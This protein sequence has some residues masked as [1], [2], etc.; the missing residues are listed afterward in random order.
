VNASTANKLIYRNNTVRIYRNNFS[1]PLYLNDLIDRAQASESASP[2]TPKP[3][4]PP[5]QTFILRA[6]LV[7]LTGHV[8]MNSIANEPAEEILTDQPSL[9]ERR[10]LINRVAASVHF[11]RSARLRDFLLYVGRQ[12]LKNGCPEIN[13][14]EIGVKVFGRSSSY[15]RSQDNIVRVNATELR[16]R[17]DLYFATEGAH[18]PL[19]LEIPRGGYRPVFHRRLPELQE[20]L[21]PGSEPPVLENVLHHDPT[22]AV[23]KDS[24][25]LMQVVWAAVTLALA[26]LCVV[27]FLQN[28]TMRRAIYTWEG[29]P[30]VASLWTDFVR[31]HQE[32]D[33]VLPD[34]SVSVSEEILGHP[35]SL[36]DYLDHNYLRLSQSLDLSSDRRVDLNQIFAHNLVTMGD[37]HAA[38][39]I[40]ALTPLS[41]TLHLTFSRFYTADSV[42]R[43][44]FILIGGKKANPWVRL[45]DD[46]MNFSLDYDNVHSQSFVANRHPQAGEQPTYA[47]PMD[48]NAFVG[49]SVVAYLPNP[50]RT[51]N[52]IILAGTDSD[53]TSAAAEFLTSEEQLDKLRN[54]LH[55]RQF[56]YFEVLLKTSRLSGTSFSAEPLAFRTYPEPR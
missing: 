40:L 17:I 15:N 29:K 26:V 8:E 12:S 30:A 37:F 31:S 21:V 19:V 20:Q 24:T 44:S 7:P 49:Y 38:Q 46:Q 6:K 54:T 3:R 47:A 42:K 56:P 5:G 45:F 48:A 35:M 25:R 34:A 36:S 27:L 4:I 13:E 33:I 9:D 28:R 39:Q 23:P 50:S 51:G 18:E 32:I 14:Q 10:S 55:S 22:H 16:K 2:P 52:V 11:R 43:N 1:K 53:A 41:P